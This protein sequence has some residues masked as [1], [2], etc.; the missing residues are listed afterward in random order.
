MTNVRQ[1][2]Q[3]QRPTQPYER[4]FGTQPLSRRYKNLLWKLLSNMIA[5]KENLHH[6]R[7]NNPSICPICD[8]NESH[9]HLILGFS[10]TRPMWF[11]VLVVQI[12]SVAWTTNEE[13]LKC[14]R[15]KP[16]LIKSQ[17][18][19]RWTLSML[20]CWFIR[21]HNANVRLNNNY[22]IRKWPLE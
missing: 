7:M 22:L 1:D 17:R 10:W 13:W 2:K 11:S 9:E 12:D 19:E 4:Q 21:N 3:T 5:T 6:H 16:N 15:T 18:K 14:R 8:G 20:T